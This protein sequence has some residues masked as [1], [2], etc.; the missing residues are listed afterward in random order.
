MISEDVEIYLSG[1]YFEVINI[2]F[3]DASHSRPQS[4]DPFGQRQD[5]SSGDNNER[6]CKLWS[7]GACA[8]NFFQWKKLSSCFFSRTQNA[9]TVQVKVLVCCR[10]VASAE[11]SALFFLGERLVVN[12]L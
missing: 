10:I 6:K 4:R 12:G 3:V 1:R 11:P 2:G 8:L 9:V 5:R 7:L